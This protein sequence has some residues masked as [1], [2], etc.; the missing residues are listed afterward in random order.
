MPKRAAGAL[1]LPLNLDPDSAIPLYRQL[2]EAMRHAILSGQLAAGTR[3]PSTRTLAKTL[4][5]ARTTVV[6][7]FEQ[8]LAEGYVEGQQGS[9]TYVSTIL[10]L[11]P[12]S[13][14]HISGVER[15]APEDTISGCS[16]AVRRISRRGQL[17]RA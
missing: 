11:E 2:Y 13:S 1:F 16:S 14:R 7:A 8:L 4:G 9:G 5:I 12:S 10:P 3:L 6:V 15:T 17:P